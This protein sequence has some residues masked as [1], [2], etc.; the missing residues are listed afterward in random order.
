MCIFVSKTSGL[1][2]HFHKS[3]VPPP[4][5][6]ATCPVCGRIFGR[7][8]PKLIPWNYKSMLAHLNGSKTEEHVEFRRKNPDGPPCQLTPI[9]DTLE[10]VL[11]KTPDILPEAAPRAVHLV[12]RLDRG[13]SGIVVVAVDGKAAAKLQRA[14][15]DA[16]KEYVCFVRGEPEEEF[17][18]DLDLVDKYAKP[19]KKQPNPTPRPAVTAFRVL[20]RYGVFALLAARLVLGGRTHQIRRHLN[21]RGCQIVGDSR[22]GKTGINAWVREEFGLGRMFLHCRRLEMEVGGRRI[23]VEDPL[24]NQLELVAFLDKFERAQAADKG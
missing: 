15:P 4:P 20:R 13:T 6:R 7:T 2:T 1:N 11:R 16:S 3:M 24:K 18:V 22:Y 21:S 10:S 17:V 8:D 5:E 9:P 12:N 23:V 19:G 14:W